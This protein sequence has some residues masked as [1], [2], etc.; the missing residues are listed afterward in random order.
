V[1]IETGRTHQI[2]VHAAHIGH[3]VRATTSTATAKPTSAGRAG[4][5]K[6]LFL[7]AAAMSFDLAGKPYTLNAPLADELCRVWTGCRQ[8]GRPARTRQAARRL[9]A[10]RA[11][12][13]AAQMKSF[14]LRPPTSW[15]G[16]AHARGCSARPGP[17][18]GPRVGDEGERIHEGHRAVVVLELEGAAESRRRPR[19]IPS[20]RAARRARTASASS[21]CS[22]PRRAAVSRARSSKAGMAGSLRCTG[23]R[24]GRVEYAMIELSEPALQHFRGCCN[25]RAA[26]PSASAFSA[27]HAGTPKPMP[28]GICERDDLQGDEWSLDC[29]GFTLYVDADSAPWLDGAQVDYASNATGGQLTI[30]A[31]RS[32]ARCRPRTP[33]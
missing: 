8:A 20:G 22:A 9:Q 5:L 26:T 11:L 31:R 24:A 3:P 14:S 7:H 6:R 25:P 29:E 2:R 19:Q 32:R 12:A 30:R 28:A 21:R 27:V 18:G 1:I 33:R 4:G 17:G 15:V 13:F 10:T 16:I 23:L